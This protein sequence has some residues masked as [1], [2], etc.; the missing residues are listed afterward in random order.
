M[1]VCILGEINKRG[2]LIMADMEVIRSNISG[3]KCDNPECKYRDDEVKYEDYIHWLNKPCPECGSNLLTEA[4]YNV[5]LKMVKAVNFINR[6]VTMVTPPFMRK[7]AKPLEEMDKLTRVTVEL[8]GTGK[9]TVEIH[10]PEENKK[11]NDNE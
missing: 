11:V 2:V 10:E 3:I 9:A 8:N 1:F 4:D 6:L 7:K 5:V